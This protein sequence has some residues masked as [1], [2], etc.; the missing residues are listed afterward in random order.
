MTLTSTNRHC[1]AKAI[2]KN[3]IHGHQQICDKMAEGLVH[4]FMHV[5]ALAN[6]VWKSVG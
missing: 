2:C 5:Y 1:V 6:K 3:V 4:T